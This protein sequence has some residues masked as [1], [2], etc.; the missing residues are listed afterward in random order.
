MNDPVEAEDL[1]LETFM[2][3]YMRPPDGGLFGS[4][5]CSLG[6]WL[7]R[8][9]TNLRLHSI[10]SFKRRERYEMATGMDALNDASENW[11]IEHLFYGE[12]RPKARLVLAR[13]NDRQSQLL[14]MRY[15]GMSY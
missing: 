8:V 1:A 2:R 5:A 11:P 15:S 9:A 10:R 4:E 3:L 6:I 14:V 12:E 7:H 13:M